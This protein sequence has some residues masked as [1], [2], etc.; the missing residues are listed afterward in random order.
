MCGG[1]RRHVTQSWL[2][3]AQR[4][5][6]D[7]RSIAHAVRIRELEERRH[8]PRDQAAVSLVVPATHAPLR[9]TLAR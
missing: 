4:A 6:H 3:R 9:T 8:D 5:M 1:V 2:E 7:A